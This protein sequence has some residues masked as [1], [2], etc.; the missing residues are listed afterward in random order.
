[1]AKLPDVTSL[2]A[3]PVPQAAFSVATVRNAGAVGQALGDVG[4]ALAKAGEQELERLDK[5]NYAAA[6]AALLKADTE[7]RSK[8]QD[9]PDFTT[10]EQRYTE[11]MK[12]ASE[13]AGKLIRNRQDRGLFEANTQV[14]LARGQAQIKDFARGKWV[15]AEKATLGTALDQAMDVGRSALDEETRAAAVTTASELYDGAVAKGILNPEEAAEGK[16][17]WASNYA[18]QQV[19]SMINRD[20]FEGAQAYFDK[21][22]DMIDWKT[23]L[24][25]EERITGMAQQREATSLVDEIMGAG[26]RTEAGT[27]VNYGDPLRGR[28]RAPVPGG[29]FGASRDYGAHQGVDFPAPMGTPIYSMGPGVAKVTSSPKGGNIVAITHGD[30]TVTRYMHMGAVNVKDGDRVTP[31]TVIGTVGMTGRTSGAHLHLETR[32]N[33][34]AVDPSTVIGRASSS[35]KKHDL[36][37]L[38]TEVEARAAAEGWSPEKLERVRKE[39]DARVSRDE[40]L[41]RREQE[42]ESEAAWSVVAR[43]GDG[44]TDVSQIPNFHSLDPKEKI[45][46]ANR[47]EANRVPKEVPA[48]GDVVL[49]LGTEA[50]TDPDVF[51]SRNLERY[52]HNMTRAEFEG[53]VLKQARLKTEE[54]AAKSIRGGISSTINL[55]ATED[56]KLTGKAN[57]SR[58][59]AVF[60]IMENELTRVTGGKRVPSDAEYEQAWKSATREVGTKTTFLGITTGGNER[61]RF[62]LT[63]DQASPAVRKQIRDTYVRV[64]GKEPDED[65]MSRIYREG[66]GTRW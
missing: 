56:M 19:V 35:P 26:T 17:Q 43:L 53:L 41:Y 44:F 30:G 6:R 23:G 39:V 52:R 32:K 13:A 48:N 33:G 2:G 29:R 63:I 50:I 38:Y 27:S 60:D 42:E 61:A 59:L 18:Q 31:D 62:E 58:F 57:R 65:T 36:T 51:A 64:Y 4:G 5:M 37:T 40:L 54:P 55:Y 21:H 47:A 45:T 11:G 24:A 8:L 7:L 46:L 49:R 14:D 20:D 12:S 9:D 16:R 1:M 22:R 10:Y 15:V 3:R 28:G 25:L 34:K 66:K